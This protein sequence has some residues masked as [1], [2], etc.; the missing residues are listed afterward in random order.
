GGAPG[1]SARRPHRL[2][3]VLWSRI[4]R[5]SSR[6]DHST[7]EGWHVVP[8]RLCRRGCRGRIVCAKPW[9]SDTLTWR[10]DLCGLPYRP[11]SW[12]RRQFY[13]RRIVGTAERYA[14]GDGI[15]LRWPAASSSKPDL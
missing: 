1:G 6:R 5:Y 4:F 9:H 13:Q 14:V 15:S 2:C 3:A 7:V 10:C 12:S 11:L 8:R